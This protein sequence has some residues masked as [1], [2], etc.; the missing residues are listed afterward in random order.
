M[1]W[2][3]CFGGAHEYFLPTDDWLFRRNC[4]LSSN[5]SQQLPF[6]PVLPTHFMH[7]WSTWST[8]VRCLQ[9]HPHFMS[10]S[11]YIRQESPKHF[12]FEEDVLS[13][14]FTSEETYLV[15]QTRRMVKWFRYPCNDVGCYSWYCYK[16]FKN[17]PFSQCANYVTRN[18]HRS[19]A[20]VQVFPL[21][22]F[23]GGTCPH[24]Y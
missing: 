19:P 5:T 6:L 7:R 18:S 11:S 24:G 13:Y 8:V 22:F 20:S 9:N 15:I 21:D 17:L 4:S 1:T 23:L 14:S 12:C 2:L 3:N 10:R 16:P